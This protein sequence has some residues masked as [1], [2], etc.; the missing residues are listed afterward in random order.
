MTGNLKPKHKLFL[1]SE[2]HL[3]FLDYFLL[4]R[5]LNRPAGLINVTLVCREWRNR[6]YAVFF[7]NLDIATDVL[8]IHTLIGLCHASAT[9][10]GDAV[11]GAETKLL[12]LGSFMKYIS[13]TLG[14]PTGHGT[15]VLSDLISL[16][17]FT[18]NLE[19]L[20]LSIIQP[21][22]VARDLTE[23]ST[24]ISTCMLSLNSLRIRSYTDASITLAPF[25]AQCPVL[26][27]ISFDVSIDN[28]V[29]IENTEY[30]PPSKLV[31]FRSLG[32]WEP[33]D[34]VLEHLILAPSITSLRTIE[35]HR[36]PSP[37]FL[38]ELARV[39]GARIESLTL[40]FMEP[41]AT[42]IWTETINQ[43]TALQHFSVWCFP[44][45]SLL[46]FV[47]TDHL[48]HFEF[49]RPWT[50][51][52]KDESLTTDVLVFLKRC[53][54]LCAITYHASKPMGEI[55][56]LAREKNIA[57]TWQENHSVDDYM[58]DPRDFQA[59]IYTSW[60]TH[61]FTPSPPRMTKPRAPRAIIND[62]DTSGWGLPIHSAK[63]DLF[64]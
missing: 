14:Q 13:I 52:S 50:R 20:A 26:E 59:A 42:R 35:L 36:S 2:I 5:P 21:D 15:I 12:A 63:S 1:P 24:T 32:W 19:D 6:T 53:P 60:K 45:A 10:T 37:R 55:D 39:H 33:N 27:H 61:A 29:H 22:Q 30:T 23:L 8:A 34:N 4:N 3:S 28:T 57:L 56:G 49:R 38:R 62:Y 54:A 9:K 16:L 44:S 48:R 25:V 41:V 31:S 7:R 51:T 11:P 47:N 18:P 17:D 40:R 64:L 58:E 46:D 43:F